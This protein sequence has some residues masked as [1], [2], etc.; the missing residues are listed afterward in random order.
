M[1]KTSLTTSKLCRKLERNVH[2]KATEQGIVSN[3]IQ[4]MKIGFY[5]AWLD[6]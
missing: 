2:K 5:A 1:P 6:Q 4:I 3:I